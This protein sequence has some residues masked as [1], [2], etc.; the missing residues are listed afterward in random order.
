M[1]QSVLY[2][3]ATFDQYGQMLMRSGAGQHH[4]VPGPVWP[5]LGYNIIVD[6][7]KFYN[8]PNRTYVPMKYAQVQMQQ[9]NV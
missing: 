5:P 9:Q 7:S 1:S 3:D 8:F 6:L 2:P 4:Y